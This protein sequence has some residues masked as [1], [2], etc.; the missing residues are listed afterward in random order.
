MDD[1]RRARLRAQ[2]L[3]SPGSSPVDIVR[4]LVGLQS[5]MP[6]ATALMVRAR[7]ADLDIQDVERQHAEG[8][9]VRTWLMRGT[10]HLVA[11]DDVDW[12]L[13]LL[14]P[15]M[16]ARSAR[17]HGELGL[18]EK[19]LV[20]SVDVVGRALEGGAATRS[21]LFGALA[22]GGVDPAG[23]RGIHV[24]RHAALRGLLCFGPD[25]DGE[26]TW[27]LR[28]APGHALDR[29]AAL[30]ELARRYRIG[31]GPSDARDLAAWSGL[32]VTDA[33]EAW[34]LAGDFAADDGPDL[35][36]AVRM[37]P[38]FDPYL[39]GYANRDFAVP[40]KHAKRVWTG[41]GYVLPTVLLDGTAMATWRSERRSRVLAVEVS[42]FGKAR[43]ARGVSEAIDAEVADIGRF[44]GLT[45][46]RDTVAP[47][48]SRTVAP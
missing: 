31:H 6:S 9:L 22:A 10:I 40:K 24:I 18:D 26:Q 21:E 47:T 41:G 7:S 33:R 28:P 39:L 25:G 46:R 27:T 37:V 44:L 17:R 12:L 23:Q 45:A 4:R 8:M 20:R 34:R 32:P 35:E 15:G 48:R 2:G 36:T 3:T 38:H 13:P 1:A 43:L 11:A 29:P 5:Q 14:G 19:T 30:A 42:T 16:I